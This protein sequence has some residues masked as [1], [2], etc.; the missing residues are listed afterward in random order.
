[1]VAMTVI[2]AYSTPELAFLAADSFRWDLV[3]R[4]N[5][6]PVQKIHIADE[7]SAFAMGGALIDRSRLAAGLVEAHRNGEPFA[8][9]ARR[10][11]PP[12]FAEA[13]EK[14]RLNPVKQEQFCISWY[15]EAGTQGCRINR[16]RLPEDTL[17]AINGLDLM[18]PDTAW[19]AGEASKMMDQRVNAGQ[20]AL[21]ELAFQLIG[22]AAAR[23]PHNVGYP[24]VAIVLRRNGGVIIRD[25]L[26]PKLWSGS[27][28]D[29]IVDLT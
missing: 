26:H 1:M 15:A 9:A 12:L 22:A 24:A 19:L 29:F 2:I 25:D 16:H 5:L 10:L 20:I 27:R 7:R 13:R 6:G 17:D 23:H 3:Q 21:D 28:S 18:G 14:L 8:N 11:S 4:R